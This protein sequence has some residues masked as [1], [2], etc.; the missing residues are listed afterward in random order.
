MA[1]KIIDSSLD[2]LSYFERG[3]IWWKHLGITLFESAEEVDLWIQD[4]NHEGV[5]DI[6]RNA[7]QTYLK[8][9]EQYIKRVPSVMLDYFRWNFEEIFRVVDLDEDHRKDTATENIIRE[10]MT[11]YYI[12]ICRDGSY[13]WLISACWNKNDTIA[14]L[15]SESE[16]RVMSHNELRY[17]HKIND[18]TIGL[19][20]HD[21]EASW[22]G[23][24]RHHFFG[25]LENLEIELEGSSEEGITPVQQ[26]AYAE[27][28]QKKEELFEAFSKMMLTAYVGDSAQVDEMLASGQPIVVQT[29]LPKTLYIDKAGNYGWIC[30]TAW[31]DSYMGVLLSEAQIQFMQP[32]Q[33]RNYRN[34]EKVIDEVCGVLFKDATGWSKEVVV[35]LT[36]EICTMPV[37]IR[38][39][40][41]PVSDKQRASYQK[42]IELNATRWEGIK[43]ATLDYYMEGYDDFVE[44]L[45][46]PDSLLRENVTRENVVP[47]LLDFT[48]LFIK[49]NGRIAWLCECPTTDDGL[50]FEFTNG[51]IALISQTD[52]V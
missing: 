40:G 33:L 4:E 49:T 2:G 51:E 1:K 44:Y 45:D 19:L 16:P 43:D 34:E 24:E 29:V 7:Y 15:L 6:Q 52:I 28:T 32:E 13:G 42:F 37:T 22:K 36:E 8:N 11:V 18:S 20:V 47:G 9:E 48:Q 12:F 38:T 41:K 35:R 17:L 14:V 21:C 25:E 50:A 27:Y 23:L 10:L 46:L 30:Y 39:Y 31:N 26:K 3:H 5:T